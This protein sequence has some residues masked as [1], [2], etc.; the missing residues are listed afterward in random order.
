M[1]ISTSN[2]AGRGEMTRADWRM[3]IVAAAVLGACG[4]GGGEAAP[5]PNRQRYEADK[6]RC[7]E[8]SSSEPAQKSCMTYRGW[9]DG[10]YR[11]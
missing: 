7:E 5:D 6:K 11:R 9:K 4:G 8:I 10:K 3:A 2:S 1:I